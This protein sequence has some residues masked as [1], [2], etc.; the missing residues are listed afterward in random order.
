MTKKLENLIL[1]VAHKSH[2][3]DY[4][5]ATKLNKILVSAHDFSRDLVL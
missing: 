4:F 5:S 2:D 1:Y 3:D